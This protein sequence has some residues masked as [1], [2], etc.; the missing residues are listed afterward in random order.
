MLGGRHG[1]GDGNLV[2]RGEQFLFGK[3]D[4][5]QI[6]IG[7]A[8]ASGTLHFIV[9]KDTKPPSYVCFQHNTTGT[10]KW[11]DVRGQVKEVNG[12]WHEVIKRGPRSKVLCAF[13]FE[14]QK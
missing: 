1:G 12:N 8:S 14:D 5:S 3:W 9:V 10:D 13:A 6:G 7:Y 11:M 4:V 2:W